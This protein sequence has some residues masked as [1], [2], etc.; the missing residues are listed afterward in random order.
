MGVFRVEEFK[1]GKIKFQKSIFWAGASPGGGL[2]HFFG[3]SSDKLC[4]TSLKWQFSV[5]LL[6]PSLN[7]KENIRKNVPQGHN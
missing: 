1:N 2:N 7:M 4:K 5:F 6:S 3:A